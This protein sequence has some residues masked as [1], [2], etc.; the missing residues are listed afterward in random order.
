MENSKQDVSVYS[1]R[2]GGNLGMISFLRDYPTT[3]YYSF[4]NS[5]HI[6]AP[7]KQDTHRVDDD[8]YHRLTTPIAIC[9]WGMRD[10]WKTL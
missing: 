2:D 8:D 6:V 3:W 5:G 10:I 1:E 7:R 4:D 9:Y